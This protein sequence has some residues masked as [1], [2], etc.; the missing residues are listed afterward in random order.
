MITGRPGSPRRRSA[1]D[2]K[3]N[4]TYEHSSFGRRPHEDPGPGQHHPKTKRRT[5]H[6]PRN[7][8]G[9]P[10]KGDPDPPTSGHPTV[11]EGTDQPSQGKLNPTLCPQSTTPSPSS[12]TDHS[13]PISPQGPA[14]LIPNDAKLRTGA[15]LPQ[16]ERSPGFPH[17]SP[18][19]EVH[20][21]RPGC[22]PGGAPG[23]Y[24]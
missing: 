23:K 14:P 13:P 4:S 18:S 6:L 1:S 22:D 12:L 20:P 8:D 21:G 3:R 11:P 5:A 19:P 10:P 9:H 17:R 2:A 7:P 24:R 15:L 16:S